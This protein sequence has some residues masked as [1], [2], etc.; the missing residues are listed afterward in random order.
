MQECQLA[1][2]TESLKYKIYFN[3]GTTC[4]LLLQAAPVLP[5]AH[6]RASWGKQPGQSRT[7]PQSPQSS[8]LPTRAQTCRREGSCTLHTHQA[9]DQQR[10]ESGL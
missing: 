3:K 4:M 6:L 2:H 5:P 7:T 9:K 10:N 8:W 1:K